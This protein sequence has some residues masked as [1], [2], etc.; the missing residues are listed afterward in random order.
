MIELNM[1]LNVFKHCDTWRFRVIL[2]KGV[3]L[4]PCV[5]G[6]T[7]QTS[8]EAHDWALE[9]VKEMPGP[10]TLW[11]NE[12]RRGWL[13]N[14]DYERDGTPMFLVPIEPTYR[15]EQVSEY[16]ADRCAGLL[17]MRIVNKRYSEGS[18]GHTN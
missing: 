13:W 15:D 3:L 10:V 2:D 4:A 17:G 9:C 12:T 14:I 5:P 16:E 18:Y 7:R 1:V 6:E 8:K 11:L